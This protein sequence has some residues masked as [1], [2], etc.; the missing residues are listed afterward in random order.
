MIIYKGKYFSV[1]A[2][3][4]RLPNKTT[5]RMESVRH[6]GA[7]SILPVR[8]GRIILERQYRPVI[9][10]WLYEIP[11]GTLEAG[12]DPMK[13]AERELKEE[14]GLSTS[15][16]SPMFSSL[17]SPGIST[18]V[19]HFFLARGLREGKQSLDRHEIIKTKEFAVKRLLSMIR[20]GEITDGKTIQAVL[21]YSFFVE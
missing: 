16:I 15:R 11:A 21:Y 10:K 17:P 1:E 12:E 20:K 4:V 9:G 3:R 6:G 14:T 5:L 13:C 8:G 2:R 18:E 19:M 7:V